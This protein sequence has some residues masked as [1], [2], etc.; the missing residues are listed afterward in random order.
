MTASSPIARA[1][2]AAVD[3]RTHHG[4]RILA[5]FATWLSLSN[6][7][8]DRDAIG[9]NATF[10]AEAMERRR[11]TTERWQIDG[12]PPVVFGERRVPGAATT[13]LLYAH[14][15]G[16]PADADAWTTPPWT[17]TLF[18][19]AIPLGGR[20]I[21]FPTEGQPIDLHWRLYAR[22][23]SDDKAPFSAILAA[24]DALDAAGLSPS[25]NLKC[26]FD[27]EEEIGSPTLGRY[28][29]AHRNQ[30]TADLLLICDG[31]VHQNR[32]PQLFF[33]ARGFSGFTIT[34]YGP[35]RHLHSGHYGNWAPNPGLLLAR[36]LAGLKDESG[37]VTIEGFYDDVV[38]LNP[39]ERA[40][41][42]ALPDYDDAIRAE[43]GLAETESG[44]ARL[45]E[46]IQW[47]SMNVRGIQCGV[48]DGRI[49]NMIPSQARASVDVRLVKGIRP[50]AMMERVTAHLRAEGW[51]LVDADPDAETRRRHAK[52]A[53][54]EFD[55]AYPAVR[56]DMSLPLVRRLVHI[57]EEACDE[58][59]ALLP[60]LG[61]SLPLYHFADTLHVPVVGVPI[62]NHDNNQHGPDENL[63]IANLWFGIDLFASIFH[64]FAT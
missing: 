57:V 47:P 3:F 23:A 16:Q 58:P 28:L 7:A 59:V 21:P 11:F 10:L 33:G 17:P 53:K 14:Y 20:P 26:F 43:L 61:G 5:D 15:D 54:L 29:A 34:V 18:S 13:L 50:E 35:T 51:H 1:R 6:V 4:A 30:L 24:L 39:I 19:D 2:Q 44:N 27:G 25:V 56:T 42:D 8:A 60:T 32:Q 64:G 22:S 46:R 63:R 41:L 48:A 31:P 37:H 38:P 45:N 9:R 12:A 49:V 62:A 40:A 55:P 36:L 52:I